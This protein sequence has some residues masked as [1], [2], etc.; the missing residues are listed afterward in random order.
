MNRAKVHA[1]AR[2][3]FL[4][5]SL[6]V[7]LG[8]SL[9]AL[10]LCAWQVTVAGA[11]SGITDYDD[12]VYLGA[13]IR[14]VHGALPYEDFVF[15][16]PPGIVILMSPV[17]L[18]GRLIGDHG[19]LI[20]ARAVT[21]LVT[22]ANAGL[23][24]WLVRRRGRVAMAI[25]GCSLAAFPLAV[26]A[27]HTLAL[28]PY[29]VFFILAGAIVAFGSDE[30]SVTRLFFA[31]ALFGVAGGIKLWALFPFLA[32]LVCFLPRWRTRVLP[33]F[34]G[35]T[36][37]FVILCLPFMIEAPRAFIHQ[38]L[39]D[40]LNLGA[41]V[42]NTVSPLSRLLAIT[43]LA[44]IPAV[45]ASTALALE[46]VGVLG[47]T[48]A[49]AF[50][51]DRSGVHRVDEFVLLGA[52]AATGGIIA[53]PE[54]YPHYTYFTASLLAA[55]L[56]VSLSGSRSVLARLS[57]R[58]GFGRR[59]ARISGVVVLIA[60]GGALIWI[61]REDAI[62]AR[63]YFPGIVDTSSDELINPGA[64]IDS[65]IPRGACVVF[66]EP[67]LAIEA[68]RFNSSTLHCPQLVDPYGMW[69]ADSGGLT[70][71]SSPPYPATFVATW[72]SYFEVARYAVFSSPQSDNVPWTPALSIW[73]NAHYR[74]ILN[75]RDAYVY[76]H[77]VTSP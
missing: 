18:I 49:V 32:L 41:T 31:G 10:G 69:L 63:S 55:L 57:A 23:V 53:F 6:A 58:T 19:A 4:S 2:G 33:L 45:T 15:V 34:I 59:L 62:Y 7:A 42:V 40:Q 8:V 3:P 17:A 74:R 35:A 46:F 13:A 9:L 64:A 47:L 20:V 26:T 54:F 25:A 39:A 76:F 70:P 72:H 43:G 24:A 65:A 11:V 75:Q 60:A 68:N 27:D 30:P 48:G 16:Q 1:P 5:R 56:A 73:F 61:V 77:K 52:V 51:L 22:G 21:A 44:G 71:P 37:G 36:A 38:V 67:I 29:L 28:E 66:D 14:L 50:G 12:G